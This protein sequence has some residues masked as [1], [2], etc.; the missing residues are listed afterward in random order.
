MPVQ[1]YVHTD[2]RHPNE[3][4]ALY[5]L[6][7]LLDRRYGHAGAPQVALVA[8]VDPTKEAAWHGR[9]LTQIDAVL[10]TPRL[11]AL[12]DFKNYP[13]P[14]DGLSET[15]A[16]TVRG[17]TQRVDGGSFANPYQQALAAHE[18]WSA[19]LAQQTAAV[20]HQPDALNWRHLNGLVVF[21]PYLHRESRLL[22]PADNHL[23]LAFCGIDDV[24][25]YL[26]ANRPQIAL[27]GPEI[28]A[29]A[30]DVLRARPWD[31]LRRDIA[32]AIGYLDV[33]D[34]AGARTA[35]RLEPFDLLTVGRSRHHHICI[36]RRLARV[37]GDHLIIRTQRDAVRIYDVGSRNGTY[38]NG[39]PL[40]ED[41]DMRL[42]K[43][44]DVVTLGGAAGDGVAELHFRLLRSADRAAEPDD[45]T[46]P[47]S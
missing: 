44:G 14:F 21:Y 43:D 33:A 10:L 2:P 28:D 39:A 16:W 42:L 47:T 19:F 41:G 35:Y 29:I 8:N 31:E 23:W 18:R 38:I 32:Q 5:H 36:D 46:L 25:Q 9:S 15:R 37:S 4:R 26:F 40:R 7:R 11:V 3:R 30:M 22:H 20:V 24:P 12:I 1:Y 27:V 13:D 6:A 45:T 17:T 34:A